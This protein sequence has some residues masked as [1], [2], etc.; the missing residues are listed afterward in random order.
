MCWT[1]LGGNLSGST[2]V[3]E[4]I[5]D[6]LGDG[7]L[8]P[9]VDYPSIDSVQ[10]H[11]QAPYHP[12][13]RLL[14]S[15]NVPAAIAYRFSTVLHE[16][17]AA[18]DP[19]WQ[20]KD[21]YPV[22]AAAGA[23][24]VLSAG[25]IGD[26]TYEDAWLRVED[27]QPI[28]WE[29]MSSF[30]ARFPLLLVGVDPESG[31]LQ[32]LV[33]RL[34]RHR[35]FDPS[36]WIV[37]ESV[38]EDAARRWREL[39]IIMVEMTAEAFVR[40]CTEQMNSS[41]Y[42]AS[43][44]TPG[45]RE[46]GRP[47]KLLDW[48]DVEDAPIFYARRDETDALLH[49]VTSNRLVVVTGPSGAGK[50]SLLKAGLIAQMNHLHPYRGLYVR[51]MD[52]PVGELLETLQRELTIRVRRPNDPRGRRDMWRDVDRAGSLPVVVF[53][54]GEELFTRFEGTMREDLFAMII[55]AV[56]YPRSRCRFV[57]SIREDYL[58][59]LAD[60]AGQLPGILQSSF[61]V[62]GLTRG[63]AHEAIRKPFEAFG[64]SLAPGLEVA[65]TDDLGTERVASPQ[66]QIVCDKLYSG[67]NSDRISLDDY[68]FLGGAR[69][70]LG[71][72]LNSQLQ[73]LGI[74]RARVVEI[75]KSLVTSEGT[76]DVLSLPEVSE[77]SGL[78]VALCDRLIGFLTAE[79]RLLRP[80][81]G[82][83]GI[84]YELAH[85]YLTHEIWQWMS[86]SDVS[87]R[88][89]QE[90]I[91]SDLRAWTT[92]Q[93][94]RLGI[95]RLERYERHAQNIKVDENVGTLLLLSCVRHSRPH[96]IWLE[97]I[98]GLAR[99]TQTRIA[100]SL[101]RFVAQ[102]SDDQRFEAAEAVASL[103]DEVVRSALGA[104]DDSI[105]HAALFMVGGLRVAEARPVLLEVLRSTHDDRS[106]E[107][108]CL[109]L[110]EIGGEGTARVLIPQTLSAS[111]R[112]A[113]AAVR[114]LGGCLEEAAFPHL[115]AAL[116]ELRPAMANAAKMGVAAAA[117]SAF[118]K[119]LAANMELE[120]DVNGRRIEL[121]VRGRLDR[122]LES[123][124]CMRAGS[125]ILLAPFAQL[126]LA[127]AIDADEFSTPW[128]MQGVRKIVSGKRFA[129]PSLEE[130]VKERLVSADHVVA[131][132]EKY[133]TVSVARRLTLDGPESLPILRGLSSHDSK[134]VR[135]TVL[136]VLSDYGGRWLGSS[137]RAHIR[138]SVLIRGLQ[139]TDP[140]VRYYAC[141]SVRN[142]EVVDCVPHLRSLVRDDDW[143]RWYM[144]DVGK[145][146]SDAAKLALDDLRPESH[147]W[148]RDWQL[149]QEPL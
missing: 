58:A 111:V 42:S 110:G 45:V 6:R 65:I 17:L 82:R 86:P 114:G 143:V 105:R 132:L 31:A 97:A 12:M 98:D 40:A 66:I 141:L 147:V 79:A 49:L 112:V 135:L 24:L 20:L 8:L 69:G 88:E 25:E 56:V 15:S 85:E 13:A 55:E 47:F 51:P 144:R 103:D 107:L 11:N 5:V 23:K 123:F 122:V 7:R 108:A 3:N 142:L 136:M 52:D 26:T 41:S 148:R 139:D 96:A 121:D 29:S 74:D 21:G 67:R 54:Q 64:V 78:A 95:D 129:D 99:S 27:R 14:L 44:W 137:W 146:V 134:D 109:A 32:D 93:S 127:E 38:S 133:E 43:G 28:L 140:T 62:G 124:D 91:A 117:S 37:A 119:Y 30:A 73:R 72:F 81:S 90:L 60:F 18:A 115:M 71:D 87:R 57:L 138:P 89:A 68:Q 149:E 59:R 4:E 22:R 131:A 120:Y 118:S 84:R 104:T 70:I 16:A 34:R 9:L 92:F 83:T 10:A 46:A 63:Q 102:Q 50:T 116:W 101:L 106:Q 75:L 1:K 61:Y 53:D 48:Y 19:T 77:R 2:V 35:Y 113:S 130:E 76:K 39:G 145:R 33:A 94:L 128:L 80:V 125:S 36:G 126:I 100:W